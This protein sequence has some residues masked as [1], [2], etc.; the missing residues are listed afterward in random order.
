VVE[1][2]RDEPT[3]RERSAYVPVT[4]SFTHSAAWRVTG[5]SNAG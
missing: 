5:W 4:C 1:R 2:E 3:P